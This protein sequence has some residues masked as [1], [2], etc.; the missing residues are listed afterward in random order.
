M[1]SEESIFAFPKNPGGALALT[2]YDP[3]KVF[4]D[5]AEFSCLLLSPFVRDCLPYL[6]IVISESSPPYPARRANIPIGRCTWEYE[7]SDLKI[8][9]LELSALGKHWAQ[10]YGLQLV[11]RGLSGKGKDMRTW[12]QQVKFRM[13]CIKLKKVNFSGLR[14]WGSSPEEMC[15]DNKEFEYVSQSQWVYPLSPLQT[16]RVPPLAQT[17]AWREVCDS[18]RSMPSFPHHPTICP[19]QRLKHG[20]RRH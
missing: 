4:G 6:Q 1:T 14:W 20:S 10:D 12:K 7:T 16:Q 9:K 3:P 11:D 18:T 19:S 5:A 15:D 17:R 8:T 2:Y 13:L